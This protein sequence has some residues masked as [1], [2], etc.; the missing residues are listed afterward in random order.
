[1]KN[2]PFL[3]A[4]ATIFSENIQLKISPKWKGVIFPQNVLVLH[5][6]VKIKNQRLEISPVSNLIF[7][8]NR[9]KSR[10]RTEHGRM[11]GLSVTTYEH[12]VTLTS[13]K[14]Q[15]WFLWEILNSFSWVP[16]FNNQGLQTTEQTKG[17][18]KAGPNAIMLFLDCNNIVRIYRLTTFLTKFSHN[19]KAFESDTA[20]VQTIDN[21]KA[22][23]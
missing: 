17:V 22:F 16:N 19:I 11:S 23:I 15:Y 7:Q 21:F 18:I 20:R 8:H 12:D 2:R 10:N 14:V 13:Q 5:Y 9:D 3:V 6:K 1:M 4:T